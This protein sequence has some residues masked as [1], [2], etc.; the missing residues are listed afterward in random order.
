MVKIYRDIFQL[1]PKNYHVLKFTYC[2]K[3]NYFKLK[4]SD[5]LSL[6]CFLE[7]ESSS[8]PGRRRSRVRGLGCRALPGP[9]LLGR[10]R[11][12]CHTRCPC[13]CCVSGLRELTGQS[14]RRGDRLRHRR[15]RFEGR[16]SWQRRRCRDDAGAG[17][18]PLPGHAGA[19]TMII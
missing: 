13:C 1:S 15:R 10:H 14:Q 18:A 4:L 12:P 7:T 19:G 8:C 9:H 5:A 6:F 2:T 17:T 3:T 11:S 16:F